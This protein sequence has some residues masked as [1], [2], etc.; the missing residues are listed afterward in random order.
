MDD[1]TGAAAF[2]RLFG[3][4]PALSAEAPGRVNLIGEHTDYQQGFVLPTLLP[5]RTVVQLSPR[6]DQRVRVVSLAMNDGIREF[7]VGAEART[8]DW[9]DYVQGVTWGL[10]RSGMDIGAADIN[11][12]VLHLR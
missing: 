7:S 5:Q 11:G 9:L 10:R 6:A 12:A 4:P 2:A 3:A 1:A 8:G